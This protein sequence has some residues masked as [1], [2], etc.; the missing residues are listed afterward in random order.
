MGIFNSAV[1]TRAGNDL[2]VTAAAGKQIVFT[3][4]VTGCGIYTDEEKTRAALETAQALKEQKQEFPFSVWEKASEK[5]VLLT[6]LITNKELT[7]GYK[8]TE[9]GIYGKEADAETDVLCSIS[10]TESIEVSDSFPPYNGLR[11]CQI[12]QDYFVTIS[13]DAEVTV[14]MQGAPALA[15]DLEEFKANLKK[16]EIGPKSMEIENNTILLIVEDA[17]QEFNAVSYNNIIISNVVPDG[18]AENW[19]DTSATQ[20]EAN[21]SDIGNLKVLTG[22]LKVGAQPE[23][24]TMFFAQ[25]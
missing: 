25:I 6:A 16:V 14:N 23:N 15:V 3:R 21:I 9:I 4:M 24:Y 7:E 2:L 18:S 13:P 1:L 20:R 22:N 10:V 8:M 17:P 12:I 11:E 5:S 19:G